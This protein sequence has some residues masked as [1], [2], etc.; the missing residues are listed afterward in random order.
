MITLPAGA[1]PEGLVLVTVCPT[2][3]WL[4]TTR[5]PSSISTARALANV[6][7]TTSGT[8][9]SAGAV[10]AG[11]LAV[12]LV[13]GAAALE[14]EVEPVGRAGAEAVAVP[15]LDAAADV[16]GVVAALGDGGADVA[17]AAVPE[18]CGEP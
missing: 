18:D 7:P 16:V 2:R 14:A 1:W 9:T 12:A 13:A 5:N 8:G 3:G 17:P 4:P 15:V 11:A 10:E 6:M